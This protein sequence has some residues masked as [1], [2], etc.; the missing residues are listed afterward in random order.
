MKQKENELKS[1]QVLNYSAENVFIELSEI[2][3]THKPEKKQKTYIYISLVCLAN[4]YF[5]P[6]TTGI[7]SLK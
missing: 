1:K 5:I 7:S 4:I 3:I 6:H 2:L